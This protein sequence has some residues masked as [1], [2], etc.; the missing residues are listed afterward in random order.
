[1]GRVLF[2]TLTGSQLVTKLPAFYGTR[3]FIAALTRAH[4]LPLF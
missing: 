1:M 2:E 4:H 3:R